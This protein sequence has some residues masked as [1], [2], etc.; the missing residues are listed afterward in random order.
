[1]V[2]NL[3]AV[4]TNKWRVAILPSLKFM[5]TIFICLVMPYSLILKF[6]IKFHPFIVA[7]PNIAKFSNWQE[8]RSL[9]LINKVIKIGTTLAKPG[10]V[11]LNV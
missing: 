4:C 1:M 7:M 11:C 2:V 5:D 9:Y 3:I 6:F 10:T 8:I